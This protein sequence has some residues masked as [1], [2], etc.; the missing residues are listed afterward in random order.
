MRESN[1]RWLLIVETDDML[2]KAIRDSVINQGDDL[3]VSI[4]EA[5]DILEARKELEQREFHCL[6]TGHQLPIIQVKNLLRIL[7][8]TPHQDQTPTLISVNAQE[9]LR[10]DAL[11]YLGNVRIISEPSHADILARMALEEL[12]LGRINNRIALHLLEPAVDLLCEFVETELK[13]RAKVSP[14]KFLSDNQVRFKGIWAR[15][16]L[17][18]REIRTHLWLEFDQALLYH[19][20]QNYF[21][22]PA[23]APVAANEVARRWIAVLFER[24]NEMTQVILGPKARLAQIEVFQNG[25]NE[26]LQISNCYGVSIDIHTD[27]GRASVGVYPNLTIRRS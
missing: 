11:K 10:D 8:E 1:T 9:K 5:R 21:Q 23:E 26:T 22:L 25:D 15:P 18:N 7:R 17:T 12:R 19:A 20:R 3:S 24:L 16:I 2:R 4:I 13:G 6:L 14:P 27:F